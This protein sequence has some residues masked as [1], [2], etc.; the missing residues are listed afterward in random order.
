MEETPSHEAVLAA[1]D[2]PEFTRRLRASGCRRC[3]LAAGRTY[4]VVD[5]GLPAAGILIVGE[6]PGEQEDL[7]GRAFVGRAG[8]VLD[9][10]L[11]AIG[12]DPETDVLIANVVKCRPPGNRVPRAAEAA[13]CLPYLRRQIDLA[14]PHTVLL[15]GATAL[16]HFATR[17]RPAP[18]AR[19]VGQR[20]ALDAWPGIAFFAL[21]HPAYLLRS[22]GKRPLA[23]GH[24]ERVR[25]TLRAEG[26]WP[27]ERG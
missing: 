17:G 19:V 20:L 11:R 23:L 16:R 8:R 1:T 9:Q 3:A 26:A 6:A 22:P 14:R 24:L 18:M 10:L 5:R 2:Y 25:G 12:L 4:V 7:S 13:A 27:D 15:L 21:Y